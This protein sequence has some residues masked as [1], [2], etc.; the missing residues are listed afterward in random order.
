MSTK[1]FENKRWS[2]HSQKV[3]FRHHAALELVQEGSVLDIGCGDGLFLSLCR[4]KGIEAQGVDFSDIAVSHCEEQGL[5]AQRVDIS[6]GTLPFADKAF[7][8]VVALD[9][10]EHVY[11]PVPLIAEMKRISSQDII[12]SVPNFSSLPARLQTLFGRVPENN[13]P[14]KGHIYWFNYPVLRA[15]LEKNGLHITILR[16]NTPW[17][18]VPL[19]GLVTRTLARLSPHLFALSFIVECKYT[20]HD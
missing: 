11:D 5:K 20:Q 12:I 18:R 15:L 3:E 9:V 13:R 4:E 19:L 10:L 2:D 17:E 16:T 6:V 1:D 14:N 8:T 7:A